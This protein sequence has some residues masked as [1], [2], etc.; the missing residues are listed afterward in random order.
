MV[1]QPHGGRALA[2]R[3]LEGIRV[4]EVGLDHQGE[5]LLELRLGLAREPDDDVGGEGD[6][7]NGRTELPHDFEIP[8]PGVAPQHPLQHRVGAAL[9]RQV[10]VLADGRR[11]RH[12]LDDAWREV[13]GIGAGEPDPP[14]PVYRSDRAQEVREV[15]L[16][17]VIR[18]D[19]LPQERDLAGALPRE[20]LHLPHHIR[21]PPAALRPPG[22]GDDTEGALV[23]APALYR[24]ERGGTRFTHGRHVFIVLPGAE[25]GVRQPLAGAGHAD[26]LAEVAVGVGPDHQVNPRHL[27]QQPGPRRCAM[28]PTTPRTPP[29]RLWRWSSPIRPITRCS[30]FS[31]TAQVLT[32]MTS[33]SA[34]SSVRT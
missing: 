5:G 25:L 23:V 14:N 7:G 10:H 9:Y 22:I 33:A 12:R 8:L 28:Q 19:G 17:V 6:A 13:G 4:V 29:A 21:Q 3:V 2:Q 16:A 1:A 27:L 32:S 18:V 20:L 24:D 15:G 11:A 31:R 30:A 26:E 34:G